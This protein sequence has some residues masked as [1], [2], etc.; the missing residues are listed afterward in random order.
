[1]NDKPTNI[2]FGNIVPGERIISIVHADSAPTKRI[3]Q[4]SKERK[5][6]IDATNGR[7]TRSIILM[8]SNHVVLSAIHLR[9]S[10]IVLAMNKE[11][12]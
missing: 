9:R 6:C 1:M 11:N 12:I 4:E 3:V 7:K 5:M 8:D 10:A 2:G